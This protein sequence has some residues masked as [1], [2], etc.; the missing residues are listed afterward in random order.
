MR[1][2]FCITCLLFAWLCANDV[3]W[4]AVQVFAWAR[5]FTGYTRALTVSE[6]LCETFDLSKPCDLC[7]TVSKAKEEER[8][9]V[10][11]P[12]R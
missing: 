7:K 3:L 1:R 2:T 6:A 9:C 11:P 10:Q 5:M 4:N 12:S 8:Q